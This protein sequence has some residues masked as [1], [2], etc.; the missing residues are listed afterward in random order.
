MIRIVACPGMI[1]ADPGHRATTRTGRFGAASG[2]PMPSL[3]FKPQLAQ[4]QPIP[5]PVGPFGWASVCFAWWRLGKWRLSDHAQT[6]PPLL[7][8]TL[9]RC[10][11]LTS[12]MVRPNIFARKFFFPACGHVAILFLFCLALLS[13]DFEFAINTFLLLGGGGGI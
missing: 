13:A 8:L 10:I 3:G 1:Y 11:L 5:S 2:N 9:V 4:P 12:C 6:C 7:I